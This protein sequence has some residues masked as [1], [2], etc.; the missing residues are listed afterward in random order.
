MKIKTNI[1]HIIIFFLLGVNI[2]YS[3]T[4]KGT[5]TDDKGKLLDA[6]ILIKNPNS[7]QILSEFIVVTEGVFIY[8]LKKSYTD[9]GFVL[10]VISVG[11]TNYEKLV[12]P[13]DLQNLTNLSFILFKEKIEIL[14]EVFVEGK[15]PFVIKKD[16]VTFDVESYKDGT[17]KKVEDL[18][19]NLPGIEVDNNN[20]VIR[21]KGRLIETVTVEGDNLFDYNY[22]IGTKNINI[23]LVKEIEAIENYAE[24]KLLKG[25]E[26]SNKVALNLKLKEDEVNISGSSE[27]G[28]GDLANTKKVPLD[29]NV[30]LLGINKVNKSF[31]V[32]TY[33]NIGENASPFNYYNTTATLEQLKDE[34]YYSQNIIP[35]YT[36]LPVTSNNLSNINSQY[37]GNF[38]TIFRLSNTIKVKANFYYLSDRIT[39]NE[40][41][42]S[43]FFA[44]NEEFATFDN[45]FIQKKPK[46]YRGDLELKFDTSESSLLEYNL[47]YRNEDVVTGRKIFSN[48]DNDFN[49]S[50]KTSSLFLKNTLQYTKRISDS[51]AFQ[52]E[53]LNVLNNSNQN[54]NINP[55]I[56]NT[57]EF[58]QDIQNNDSE[59]ITTTFKTTFLGRKKREDNF[60]LCF[61]LNLKNE[62]FNANLL[63]R[64]SNQEIIENIS[65]NDLELSDN[66]MFTE[67]RYNFLVGKFTISPKYSLRFLRQELGQNGVALNSNNFIFEPSLRIIFKLDRT[68]FVYFNSGFNQKPQSVQNLFSNPILIDNRIIKSNIPDISLQKNQNYGI[69]FSKNDLFNQLELSFGA[70]YIK[71]KGNYFTSS[72]IDEIRIGT[73]NFFL[74]ESTESLNINLNFSKLIHFIRTTVKITSNY[75]IFNFKN[76]VNNSGLIDNKSTFFSNGVFFKT[77]FKS[78]LNF[79]NKTTLFSQGNQGQSSFFNKSIENNFRL[80]YKPSKQ[81]LGSITYNQ[82][83]PNLSDKKNAYLF[84]N[85]EISFKPRDKDWEA[86]VAGVNLLNENSFVNRNISDI[87]S[88]ILRV[89]LLQRYFLFTF[90][91]SF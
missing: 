62:T 75:S 20:G 5:V 29:L 42:E 34:A 45:N 67:G 54:L 85:S 88:N 44:N 78:S 22:S 81:I 37:F 56:L 24:N 17:E 65:S 36:A 55:S 25:I 61:G 59:K 64:N 49:S 69:M 2:N 43:T 14:D 9:S 21:Y 84:L 39:S 31:A 8:Q 76:I 52:V 89:N 46:R 87:S 7:A 83:I 47:S 33:N 82:F 60:N 58:D 51:N 26:N 53:F 6:K 30:N 23:D 28:I 86:G 35:E 70:D 71:S 68:S 77:A 38:N 63:N 15:R 27:F 1:F 74:P 50:L 80:I 13:S 3:Q 18:L 41:V 73:T 90:K 91:Y 40:F 79:E 48:Q 11:Y 12:K 10:E 16:T 19:K 72:E 57:D 4:L 32:T 66:E